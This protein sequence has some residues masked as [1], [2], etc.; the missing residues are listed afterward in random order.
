MQTAAYNV[1]YF[2]PKWCIC[3]LRDSEEMVYNDVFLI[4]FSKLCTVIIVCECIY[5]VFYGRTVGLKYSFE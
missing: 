3:T 2:Q 1:S 4:L 5:H